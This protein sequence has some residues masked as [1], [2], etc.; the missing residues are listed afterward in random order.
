MDVLTDIFHEIRP[1]IVIAHAPYNYPYRN[2]TSLWD[3]DHA[4]AG[5]LVSQALQRV[6]QPDARRERS[7]LHVAQVYYIGVEFGWTD[8]DLFVDIS[9]QVARR[10]E[11][12]ALFETQGHTTEFSRKR[13]EA[14]AAVGDDQRK[15][16]VLGFL[17]AQGK[18]EAQLPKRGRDQISASKHLGDSEVVVVDDAGQMVGG[19]LIPSPKHEVIH[20]TLQ[21]T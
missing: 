21:L 1:H 7:P 15:V 16:Q 11:A 8:I 6:A 14:F 10:I 18:I 5:Q 20:R 12:E 2:M 19:H 17:P 13:I 4:L 9:D 3:Q